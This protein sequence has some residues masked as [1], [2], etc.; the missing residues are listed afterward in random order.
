MTRDVISKMSNL[1]YLTA[2]NSFSVMQHCCNPEDSIMHLHFRRCC[3]VHRLL[4]CSTALICTKKKKNRQES[5]QWLIISRD[6][7]PQIYFF[8]W[9]LSYCLGP[10]IGRINV[11]NV[12]FCKK[13]WICWNFLFIYV[14]TFRLFRFRFQCCVVVTQKKMMFWLRITVFVSLISYFS[15]H[16]HSWRCSLGHFKT[17]HWF[18]TYK[19][20][21]TVS[22]NSH[23]PG[24]LFNYHPLHLL[25][26]QSGH[27]HVIGTWNEMSLWYTW[28]VQMWRISGLQEWITSILF[29]GL[30]CVLSLYIWTSA[31]FDLVNPSW[32]IRLNKPNAVYAAAA[33]TTGKLPEFII[34][35]K[36]CCQLRE[37]KNKT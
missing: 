26:W 18:H 22:I 19:C 13:S 11:G 21:N 3:T 25:I 30:H 33:R 20:W 15:C 2:G 37:K 7:L 14:T 27:N 34:V 8:C 16:K 32:T 28:H 10:W 4:N 6:S 12:H 24:H 1:H 23:W 35:R 31:R 9:L 36:H 5:I 17:I 29:W